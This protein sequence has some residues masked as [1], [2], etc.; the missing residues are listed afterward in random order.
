[1]TRVLVPV[2]GQWQTGDVVKYSLFGMW[3]Y[4][5]LDRDGWRDSTPSEIDAYERATARPE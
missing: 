3:K 1:M 2:D 5:T 4:M